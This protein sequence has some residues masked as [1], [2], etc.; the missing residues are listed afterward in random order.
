MVVPVL[1][2]QIIFLPKAIYQYVSTHLTL[3]TILKIIIT[4]I[5]N[6]HTALLHC[7]LSTV[8]LNLNLTEHICREGMTRH[9][10]HFT[11]ASLCARKIGDIKPTVQSSCVHNR[12]AHYARMH[13]RNVHA[14]FGLRVHANCKPMTAE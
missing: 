10:F 14:K 6:H 11:H 3:T 8:K 7:A 12:R 13:V 5:I 4:S 2:F 1:K 9:V